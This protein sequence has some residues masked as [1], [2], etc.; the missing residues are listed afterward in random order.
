MPAFL[1]DRINLGWN[2]SGGVGGP[3]IGNRSSKP[4]ICPTANI[5]NIKNSRR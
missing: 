5:Q 4:Y 1:L 3:G 2:V